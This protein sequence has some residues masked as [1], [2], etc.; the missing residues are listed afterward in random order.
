[1]TPWS[2]LKSF[3]IRIGE[4]LLVVLLLACV[5]YLILSQIGMP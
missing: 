3:A 1:M 2:L 4:I 5:G